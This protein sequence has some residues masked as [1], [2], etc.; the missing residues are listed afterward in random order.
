[1]KYI[2]DLFYFSYHQTLSCIFPM[3]IFVTLAVSKIIVIPGLHRYDILLMCF[4]TQYLMFKNKLETKGE[5]KVISV[6]HVIGF[7]LEVYKV[8][9]GSWSYPEET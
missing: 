2:Q 3:V 9:V 7:L 8:Y 1:M 4:I 6:F 5:L